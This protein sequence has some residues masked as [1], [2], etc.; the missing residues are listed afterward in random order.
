LLD[1]IGLPAG[2]RSSFALRASDNAPDLY[3]PCPGW[4]DRAEAG[5]Y[6]GRVLPDMDV[7]RPW[8][9]SDRP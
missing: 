8:R 3:D 2:A 4:P 9:R 7:G 5:Q 6:I 1:D